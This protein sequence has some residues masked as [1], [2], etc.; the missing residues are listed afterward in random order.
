MLQRRWAGRN[1]TVHKICWAD[2]VASGGPV[3]TEDTRKFHDED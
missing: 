2:F 3:E 1:V